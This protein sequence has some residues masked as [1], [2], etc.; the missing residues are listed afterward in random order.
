MR[1]ILVLT[2]LILASLTATA[3]NV[4]NY[5]LNTGD[6]TAYVT[7]HVD[8]DKNRI[9]YSGDI[10]IPDVITRDGIEYK[11]TEIVGSTFRD[12]TL[13][14]SVVLGN[15]LKLIHKNAFEGCTGISEITIP[16]SVDSIG[17]W[18]FSGSGLKSVT[19]EDGDNVI[20]LW[21]YAGYGIFH[22]NPL[23]TVYLGRNYKSGDRPFRDFK[24]LKN[25]TVSD[26]V[27][28]L[29]KNEFRS[30]RG[31]RRVSLGA[32]IT[33]IGD[34]AFYGC[35]SLV[36]IKLPDLVTSIGSEAFKYC[37]TLSS[38]NIPSK[39]KII[40]GDA[41]EYCRKLQ[42]IIIPASVDTI[43]GWA[44]ANSG[45]KN[46]TIEDGDSPLKLWDYAGYGIFHNDPLETVYLGRNYQSGDRPFRDFKTLKNVTVSDKVNALQK[47]EFRSSRGIRKVSLGANITEIGDGAFYG[48]DSLVSIKLPDLVTSIGSEAFKYCD[49]LSSIN[50]PSKVKIIYG[51]AFEYCRKLQD[52][53]IP[54]SVD[55][56]GG[57]A[58]ANSGLK[59]VTIEDGDSPLKLWD[60]AG[61]GI[62]HNYPL[63]TV[64]L[65]RNYQ[66]G[67][68]PF[69]DFKTLKNVTVSDKVSVLQKNEFRSSRGIRK[70]SL[71]AN[72]TE[73][74]DG[75]FYSCDSL[76]SIKLP[77]L[78]T[79]I[80]SE[81]FKYCDTL[82]SVNIPSKVKII[83]GDAFE[84]CRKLQNITIPASVDTIG[85]WA[86]A[87][88]GLK[89]VTIEDGDTPLKLWEYAGYG[90]FHNNPLET[91]YLGRNYICGSRPFKGYKTIKQVSIGSPVEKL[92]SGEF[93]NC[94]NLEKIYCY[95]ETPPSCT[96]AINAF[97]GVNKQTCILYVPEQS[98][99]L[100]KAADVWREFYSIVSGVKNIFSEQ[101]A[102]TNG[103]WFDLNGRQMK[104]SKP[105]LNI[106]RTKNG[107]AIKVFIP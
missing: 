16:A 15:N 17:E 4:L 80:G 52:I 55:T 87:N 102:S 13:V 83:N 31:I 106:L 11:V 91:V 30:C 7:Y 89:N 10:V 14:T 59:N 104:S 35:D 78:V 88:S 26:K 34:G 53:I 63:E 48:C 93:E 62:F 105:G 33:E 67:D 94:G 3:D 47:N 107:K 54:A 29:Q 2:V 45:L 77:D 60:Y 101:E 24:T 5:I 20:K 68:R 42:D 64:Y 37:D 56:I 92:Q 66:S 70:V 76:I 23:E 96:T 21:E 65:G 27:S 39:V 72:I 51:D 97:K 44:F 90:I 28:V 85:G 38:I 49:T 40:Y 79:S 73:I 9:K 41:F 69:R 36:S 8:K 100:Y 81:A 12:N 6:K 99:N 75:A 82:S 57:W 18:A 32:N 84:Y 61:Y 25:V 86:F 43:G 98:I 74:G 95:R 19:F 22:N 1:R 50:I 58:F 103:Q 71:G 46:V